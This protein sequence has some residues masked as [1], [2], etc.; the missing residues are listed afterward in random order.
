[1][2]KQ[3]R[4]FDIGDNIN[5]G[6]IHYRVTS[7]DLLIYKKEVT[8]TALK[9][10]SIEKFDADLKPNREYLYHII[11]VAVNGYLEFQLQFPEI[12]YN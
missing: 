2:V 1:M 10:G 12:Y 9:T 11:R 3:K 7:K 8:L 6:A 4:E 5:I